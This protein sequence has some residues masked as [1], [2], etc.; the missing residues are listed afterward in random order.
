MSTD[1][2]LRAAVSPTDKAMPAVG[3]NHRGDYALLIVL[4]CSVGGAIVGQWCENPAITV[5]N[6]SAYCQPCF[7]SAMVA[8]RQTFEDHVDDLVAGMRADTR[9]ARPDPIAILAP[10]SPAALASSAT[11]CWYCR[12]AT[13][14][15]ESD[16]CT[17]KGCRACNNDQCGATDCGHQPVA[18]GA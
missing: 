3:V 1:D 16:A 18:P 9:G 11:P 5:W 2:I 6:G 4:R 15:H 8:H 14:L 12:G 7:L 17:V 10:A 13:H